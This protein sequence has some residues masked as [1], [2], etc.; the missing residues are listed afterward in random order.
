MDQK[1]ET[2]EEE[3]LKT[4]SSSEVTIPF[5]SNQYLVIIIYNLLA[6]IHERQSRIRDMDKG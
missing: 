5:F 2:I 3:P 4:T 6:S 1:T